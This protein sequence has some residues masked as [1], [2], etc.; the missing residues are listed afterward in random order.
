MAARK[1]EREARRESGNGGSTAERAVGQAAEFGE[2]QT[3]Q[4]RSMAS[5]TARIYQSLGEDS[6]GDMDAFMQSGARLAKGM[7]D[8]GWEILQF[9]QQSLRLSLKTANDLMTCRS[10]EDMMQVQQDF[11]RES[12][13]T[14]MQESAR[15]IEL[16]NS[17][18]T[19]AVAPLNQRTGH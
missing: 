5:Q 18:A 4:I 16:S 9:G 19:D 6:R 8:M 12:M 13:D 10:V 14:I 7:Q 3:E 11:L 1:D 2:R 15:M 17:V